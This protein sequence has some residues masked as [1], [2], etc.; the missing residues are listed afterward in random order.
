MGLPNSIRNSE[1]EIKY[2]FHQNKINLT[3]EDDLGELLYHKHNLVTSAVKHE[4]YEI[5]DSD[6]LSSKAEISWN[7]EYTRDNWTARNISET[8]LTNNKK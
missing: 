7:F 2:D 1:R 8:I 3:I 6:P 5:S 4:N